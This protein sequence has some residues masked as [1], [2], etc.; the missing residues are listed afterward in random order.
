MID[1]ERWYEYQKNYQKYGLDMKPEPAERS[2]SRGRKR[3]IRKPERTGSERKL[4]FSAVLVVGI[5]MIF[6]IIM[7][8]YSANIRYDINSMIIENNAL[9]GEVENLQ[10]KLYSANNVENIESKA[11]SKLKMVYPGENNKVYISSDDIPEKG[12]ADIIKEKAYN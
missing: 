8:A 7:T 5:A 9:S 1:A 10:V 3:H 4:A 6:M 2:R 11:R 12:F